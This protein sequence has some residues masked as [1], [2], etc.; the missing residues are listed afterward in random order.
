MTNDKSLGSGARKFRDLVAKPLPEV[1]E[2]IRIADKHLA[3]APVEQRKALAMEILEAIQRHAGSIAAAAI[4]EGIKQA[5]L[6]R[7]AAELRD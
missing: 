1:T 2:A 3:Y 7:D 5:R 6:S 4:S